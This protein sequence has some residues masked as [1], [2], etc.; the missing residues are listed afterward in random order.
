MYAVFTNQCRHDCIEAY[1]VLTAYPFQESHLL[2]ECIEREIY[3]KHK[4][5]L[6][7]QYRKCLRTVVFTLKH[8]D[9]VREKVLSSDISVTELISSAQGGESCV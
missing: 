5:L 2:P 9:D 4:Q 6:S 3:F 7:K 8:K 1:A